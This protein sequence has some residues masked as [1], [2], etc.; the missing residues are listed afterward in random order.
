MAGADKK[1][2]A[3]Q[4]KPKAGAAKSD[5]RKPAASPVAR[6]VKKLV[7]KPAKKLM[8]SLVVRAVGANGASAVL[9][10]TSKK[11]SMKSAEADIDGRR[12]ESWFWVSALYR[13]TPIGAA[14]LPPERAHRWERRVFVIRALRGEERKLAQR[15]AKAH[16]TRHGV[17]KGE[18]AVWRLQ[19]IESFA[20]LFDE[21]I[22]NGTE[23]YWHFFTR[24]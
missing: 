15:V 24:E 8:K 1:K 22:E 3:K 20:E 21:R 11:S 5:D 2:P 4:K 19:E 17:P 9:K 10:K 12:T 18:K 13:L 6:A 14:S 16:E 7:K 23:V